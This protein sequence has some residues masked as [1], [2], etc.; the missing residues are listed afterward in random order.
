[1]VSP[2]TP[3]CCSSPSATEDEGHLVCISCGTILGPSA[4]SSESLPPCF[5]RRSTS[6]Y[7]SVPHNA[8]LLDKARKLCMAA[9]AAHLGLRGLGAAALAL[10]AEDERCRSVS[11]ALA[12]SDRADSPPASNDS[13]AQ[14]TSIVEEPPIPTQ[15]ILPPHRIKTRVGAALF[16]AAR[17]ANRLVSHSQ[18]AAS[19][20]LN[21][22]PTI[23]LLAARNLRIRLHLP[24]LTVRKPDQF[25][26][27]GVQSL[28]RDQDGG[29]ARG[30]IEYASFLLL[31]A[32]T[33]GM[34]ESKLPAPLAAA[35]L[36]LGLISETESPISKP[37]KQRLAN[38]LE[39]SEL[40]VSKRVFELVKLIRREL[41]DGALPWYKKE[42]VGRLEAKFD[43]SNRSFC[44]RLASVVR[45]LKRVAYE[46]DEFGVDALGEGKD[47]DNSDLGVEE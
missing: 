6:A 36:V 47:A 45:D 28:L 18:I 2:P 7:A 30:I 9:D 32:N 15:K 12:T 21:K 1:M 26:E 14:D 33:A 27:L 19:I 46:E 40:T 23:I 24:P 37:Q 43:V 11:S 5:V 35:A 17:Q 3:L 42:Y 16:V 39:C 29:F 22:D 41:V 31:L 4:L 20:N 13:A 44:V 34:G 25:L 10:F 8:L 38:A